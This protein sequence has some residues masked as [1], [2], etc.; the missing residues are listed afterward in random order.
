MGRG[1]V[2]HMCCFSSWRSWSRRLT[3]LRGFLSVLPL[4]DPRRLEKT[5][6]SPTPAMASMTWSQWSKKIQTTSHSTLILSV[7]KS[8]QLTDI[9]EQSGR[10][11]VGEGTWSISAS[12]CARSAGP[13]R[14]SCKAGVHL[15]CDCSWPALPQSLSG[16]PTLMNKTRPLTKGFCRA[17]PFSALR[18][19]D[20]SGTITDL[21]WCTRWSVPPFSWASHDHTFHPDNVQTRPFHGFLLS[22][23]CNSYPLLVFKPLCFPFQKPSYP[24]WYSPPQTHLRLRALAFCFFM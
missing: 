19:Y 20:T 1:L 12:G 8:C 10:R 13:R 23:C 5:H 6:F 3:R 15:F 4:Q 2:Y 11:G 7:L 17:F 16:P 9:T 18:D 22:W 24:F 14:R 21:Q